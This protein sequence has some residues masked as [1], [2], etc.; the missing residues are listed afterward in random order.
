M[1]LYYGSRRPPEHDEF[2]KGR[3]LL[4]IEYPS[5]SRPTP[6]APLVYPQELDGERAIAEMQVHPQELDGEMDG[7]YGET[8]R[9]GEFIR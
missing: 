4:G 6:I 2:P 1:I 5:G 8:S 9:T 3:V 7:R